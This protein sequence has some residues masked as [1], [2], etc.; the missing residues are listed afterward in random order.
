M[1][2]RHVRR[3]Y[4]GGAPV[5]LMSEGGGSNLKG[6]GQSLER[7]LRFPDYFGAPSIGGGQMMAGSIGGV[8][9]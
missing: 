6:G 2:P 7:E 1:G 8:K 4:L 3:K 9:P 5:A